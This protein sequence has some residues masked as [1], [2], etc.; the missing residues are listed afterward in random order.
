MTGGSEI[1]ASLGG[2]FLAMTVCVAFY[3]ESPP[4][5]VWDSQ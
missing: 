5:A 4:Q 1:A 2:S 3:V